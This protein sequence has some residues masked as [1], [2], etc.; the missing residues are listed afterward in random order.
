[1]RTAGYPHVHIRPSAT[2]IVLSVRGS[3]W[4]LVSCLCSPWQYPPTPEGR[5]ALRGNQFVCLNPTAV[6]TVRDPPA[7]GKATDKNVLVVL[8]CRTWLTEAVQLLAQP[9]GT[10]ALD[11]TCVCAHVLCLGTCVVAM[12]NLVRSTLIFCLLLLWPSGLPVSCCC[13]LPFSV[14]RAPSLASVLVYVSA[15]TSTEAFACTAAVPACLESAHCMSQAQDDLEWPQ[16][17]L[18]RLRGPTAAL[19]PGCA[20]HLVKRGQG[21]LRARPACPG[22]CGNCRRTGTADGKCR[23]TGP[24]DVA[25]SSHTTRCHSVCVC[26]VPRSDAS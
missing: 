3:A 23:D 5:A 17:P 14:V 1:M 9:R 10:M 15:Q 6:D 25:L 19:S 16:G 4:D 21:G 2:D 20:G 26:M 24:I 7:G 18:D 12:R 13:A 11:A 22:R 8:S